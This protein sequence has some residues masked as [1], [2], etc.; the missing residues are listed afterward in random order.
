MFVVTIVK[1]APKHS[2][3]VRSSID[4]ARR[5][6]L[7]QSRSERSRIGGGTTELVLVIVG[8]IEIV[9]VE[10]LLLAP[11]SPRSVGK[12]SEQ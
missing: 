3:E 8:V 2:L 10:G 6:I 11:D 1:P 4:R 12:T 7:I 5:V 9:V